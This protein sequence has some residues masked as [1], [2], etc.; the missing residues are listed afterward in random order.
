MK[1]RWV[2]AERAQ[3]KILGGRIRGRR[4]RIGLVRMV[5]G[6]TAMD[7]SGLSRRKASSSVVIVEVGRLYEL[8]VVAL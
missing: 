3:E 2:R 7:G 1:Y 6:E 5:S 4:T 8:D